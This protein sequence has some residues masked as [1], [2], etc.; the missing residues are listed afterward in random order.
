[1]W[2][3]L[4]DEGE[5]LPDGDGGGPAGFPQVICDLTTEHSEHRAAQIGQSGQET[6]LWWTGDNNTGLEITLCSLYL[7]VCVCV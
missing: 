5:H 6:V 4:T 2:V 7:N 1:M 3:L